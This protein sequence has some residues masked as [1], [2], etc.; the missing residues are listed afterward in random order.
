MSIHESAMSTHEPG[1]R[2][3]SYDVVV[4][5]GS[6][7]GSSLA[8]LLRRWHPQ[9][10]VLVVERTEHFNKKVGEATVEVSADFLLQVLKLS[11]HLAREHIPKHGLRYWFSKDSTR[12]LNEMSEVGAFFSPSLSTYQLDRSRLDEHILELAQ[13]EGAEYARPAKVLEVDLGWPS[14]TVVLEGAQ[15]RRE[16]RT[17]WVVDASGR[18]C[19]LARRLGLLERNG[20]HP[21][22]ALWARW[23]GVLDLDGPEV[24]GTEPARPKLTPMA[25]S[26][27][28]A[29]NHFCG[30]GWWCWMI[31]LGGG[32]TSVGLVHDRRHFDLP[33]GAKVSPRAEYENFVRTQPGLSELLEHAE[34]DG[35]DF[36]S[37][38]D[39]AYTSRRC[40][41][42]GWL[43]V[44]DASGFIDPYY[45]P[46]LDNLA[47]TVLSSVR[48]IGKDLAGGTG[49]AEFQQ[50][51]QKYDRQ[52]TRSFRRWFDALY[53]D[54]YELLGDAELTAASF[55]MD[56]SMYYLGV[57]SSVRRDIESLGNPIFG[58]ENLGAKIAYRTMR[59]YRKRLVSLARS[60]RARGTY[61]WRNEGW[62][63][64]DGNFGVARRTFT[65]AHRR[66]LALW[67][68]AE[69]RELRERW[70]F[71]APSH[72]A[73]KGSGASA[74]VG[75]EHR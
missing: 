36:Q 46:G 69:L 12:R 4:I 25:C 38:R 53:R 45:S 9:T 41:D 48:L 15:G 14:S 24:C 73:P 59:F 18:A 35:D 19:F 31:P 71:K 37:Y 16:V 22:N 47:I 75:D 33:G 64:Y 17:R 50:A 56:T 42:R 29:T 72:E 8:L 26:R 7:A 39:L 67:L 30:F 52:I 34:I 55:L 23:K 1:P 65:R 49:E 13:T 3:E 43:L 60:R 32:E 28:Q 6:L 61:G 57:L 62:R 27:R 10:R 70:S 54:K 63:V 40:A 21:V 68:G 74:L 2:S 66:G 44:G 58:V 11:D 20:D 51:V 5:G